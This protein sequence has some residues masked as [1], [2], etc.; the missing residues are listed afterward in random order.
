M[1]PKKRTESDG[2]NQ[3]EQTSSSAKC[4]QPN[5][6]LAGNPKKKNPFNASLCLSLANALFNDDGF[7]VS[8]SL[9][10]CVVIHRLFTFS[11]LL[12]FVV[13]S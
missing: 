5:T 6:F 8:L 4:K 9:S 2:S 7:G 1:L 13:E 10:L 11:R 12:R 3:T